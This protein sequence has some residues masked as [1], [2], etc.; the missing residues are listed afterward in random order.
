MFAYWFSSLCRWAT[1]PEKRP[2]HTHGL[3]PRVDMPGG[4]QP[5]EQQPIEQG[6]S[7]E[8]DKQRTSVKEDPFILAS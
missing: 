5:I 7:S 2:T 1:A 6:T 8:Q 3:D 4:E